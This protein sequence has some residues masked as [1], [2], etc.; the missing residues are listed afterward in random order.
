M[1]GGK[2]MVGNHEG[3]KEEWENATRPKCCKRKRAK[4]M[5]DEVAKTYRLLGLLHTRVKSLVMS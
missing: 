1:V 3:K 5:G 2:E 4:R